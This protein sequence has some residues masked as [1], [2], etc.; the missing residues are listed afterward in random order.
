MV[1]MAIETVNLTK[2]FPGGIQALDS[3]NLNIKAGESIG[4]LGPN[5]AG[6][7]TTIQIILNLLRPSSGDVF[8]FSERM[9]GQERKILSRIGA[10]VEL[11]GFYDNLTPNQLLRHIC[12]LYRMEQEVMNQSIKEILNLVQLTEVRDRS[13][14]T[15]STGMCRRLGIAQVLV[16]DPELIIFDEPTNGLDP[17]GIREIRDLIKTLNKNGKTVFMSSHNLPE[18]TEISDRV[19]FLKNGKIIEDRRMEELKSHLSSNII[20]LK[21]IRALTKSEKK[22]LSSISNILNIVYDHSIFIEYQGNLDTTHLILQD[23]LKNNF[24]IYSFTP[25]QMTLEELYLQLFGK[26]VT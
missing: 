7:T 3:L 9:K 14:G 18:V 19:I 12:R 24:P 6:K 1:T 5:G 26:E 11:P 22:K 20:E 8:I 17:K 13:I 15:F 25:R 10:L 16:H 4:Y 23:L 2:I 21:F